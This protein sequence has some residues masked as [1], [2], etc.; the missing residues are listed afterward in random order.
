MTGTD[1]HANVFQTL[2]T[3]GQPT[4]ATSP[5]DTIRLNER[6]RNQGWA[7]RPFRDEH[8][9]AF[10]ILYQAMRRRA[11]NNAALG[12]YMAHLPPGVLELKNLSSILVD[13]CE[14]L[15]MQAK[16]DLR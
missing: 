6:E 11:G 10:A 3:G 8:D 7:I 9:V 13:Y 2:A 16:A 14:E 15:T 12:A 5:P 1:P 4:R